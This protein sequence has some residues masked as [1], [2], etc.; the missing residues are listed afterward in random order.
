MSIFDQPIKTQIH[1]TCG[2]SQLTDDNNHF[3]RRMFR[4]WLDGSY[5]GA[6]SYRTHC[7][8]VKLNY[9]SH[10][11]MRAFVINQFCRYIARDFHCSTSHAQ[12]C[13]VACMTTDQL[14]TLNDAL[15]EDAKD[16]VADYIEEQTKGS[17]E[18]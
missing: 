6:F 5:N 3:I 9:Q 11:R 17:E 10:E 18:E 7:E 16:L 13:L 12:K 1:L 4:C 14:N 15:I 2:G 8:F